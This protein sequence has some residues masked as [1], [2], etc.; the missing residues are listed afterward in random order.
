M[1]EHSKEELW[2][3]KYD[4]RKSQATRNVNCGANQQSFANKTRKRKSTSMKDS[5]KECN[6]T[7]RALQQINSTSYARIFCTPIRLRFHRLTTMINFDAIK[8]FVSSSL[9][10]RKGLP[11]Q[12]K[13]DVYSLVTIDGDPLK[14]NDE[15]IIEEIIPL[16][17]TLQQHHEELTLDIVRMASHDIV[18]GMPWL[19]MHNPNVDWETRVLTFE[20][21]DCVIDIQLTHR[22]RSMIN[23]QTSR[24]S[25][26]KS[27]LIN[28]NKNIDE[29]MFDF[30]NIVK[31]QASHEV[32]INKGS[33]APFEISNKSRS[34]NALTRILDEY[35]Q[36]KHLFLKEITTKALFK[37]QTWDHEIILE[38]SKTFTFELI[39]ALFEKEL[40]TLREYLDENLK[41]EFIQKS[42]SSTR[43]SILFVLKKDETF[44]LCVDYRKLNEIIVKNRYSLPNINELQDRL[45]RAIYFTKLNLRGA[46]N[47]I[48]MRAGEE[49]KTAFRTRYGHYEYMVMPFG[50]TNASATYQEMI[51]DALREHL[52]V[53]VIAYLDDILIYSKTLNEHKQHVRAM[54]QCLEGRQLLLKPEKCEF[55]K[56]EVEFLGFVIGTQGV[57]M[58]PTKIK[59]IKDWP[60]STNVKEVQAF[61]G[62]VNY[63]R[64]FIKNYFKKVIPLINLTTK[65]KP[66]IWEYSKQ[67]AFEQLRDACLQQSILQMF[68]SKRSIWIETDASNLVIDACL[69][70]E[71]EGKQHFVAYFSRKLSSMEQNYDIHDKE[72]LAIITSL[73]TWKVYAEGAPKFTIYTNHKNLLQFIITKQLNRRQVRWFELLG[74]YKFTIQ[75]TPRKEN[76]RANAL[77]RRIDYMNSKEIFNHNI[78]KV[79]SNEIL[80]VNCHEVNATLKIMRDDQEQFSIVHGRLQISKDK[81]D[82]YIKE[83]HDESLQ[84]HFE[85]I[86]TIQLLRRNCQFPNMRQRVEIYIKKC[87]SYQQNKHVTHAKYE[88]IQYMNS[89]KTSWDEVFMNFII[90][91]SKSKNS[92][93]EEAYDAILVMIDRLI[94]YCHIVPFKETYNVEQLKY[95]VLNR[96]IRYQEISREFINDRDKLFTSNYWKTLLPMLGTKLK[97][98][99]TFHS[100]TNEQTKRANQSL[101]QYLKHYINNT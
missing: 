84:R 97:M 59:A 50:L 83:H 49:W 77:S 39:Y 101:K 37:H 8:N 79:N 72:L 88:E 41:K 6:N 61:L 82:E 10:D 64:K 17:M 47:L 2:Y 57:R 31:G 29:Q 23:E 40:K 38:S 54:L 12:K 30:T 42:K 87:L 62:F 71:K 45:A 94:K 33:Y 75:Y 98:S 9:V 43:Y 73:E 89:S 66:W 21:C 65:N 26:V 58:D 80:F 27:E 60:Q 51:N 96:L 24:E 90:K 1:I 70:Q 25:I 11:T 78:L 7:T 32:K 100:Q 34:R 69:N 68:D 86:K 19:K 55:H 63:N 85:V 46:Y 4:K 91:L 76:G 35:K 13:K 52:N 44:R 14:D 16:T 48:R 22:Q 67:Q 95:L 53:F 81:I 15:M 20:R 18:L 93:N 99:T 3:S 36:W 56:S 5:L 74:Q 28:A 92:T